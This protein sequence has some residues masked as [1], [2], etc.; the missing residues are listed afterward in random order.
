[1]TTTTLTNANPPDTIDDSAQLDALLSE[2]SEPAIETMRQLTGDVML[3]GV[4]GKM[5]PTLA[6]MVK[7][8]ADGA[9][10]S[11]RVIGVSR[12]SSSSGDLQQEL[13]QHSIETIKCD[14]LDESQLAKLPDCPN[15]IYMAGLKFG[16]SGNEALTWAM[17]THVPALVSQRFPQSRIAAFSTGNVYGLVPVQHG[18]SRE[19]DTPN[20][21][22]DY[23]ISCLGRERI[24]EHFSRTN[25]TPVSVIRLNYAT[26]LRYG[27]LVDIAQQ[28]H[29]G[30]PIDVT[31]PNMNV[32]WQ[33]DA[34]AY[35]IASLLHADS[36]PCWL[37]VAGP[38]LLSVRD[39]AQR[40]GELMGRDVTLTGSESPDALIN[41]GQKGHRLFGY[42]RIGVDRMLRW[43]AD[44]VQRGGETLGKP[45]HFE[46]RDGKF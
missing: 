27:V 24:F 35:T 40:F 4:G 3:L 28:V 32:I 2:P 43:I 20:P 21:D 11:R 39:V 31:M 10:T 44:W 23:A 38:E 19:A 14:L 22:G 37:N 12:F 42:P 17:N 5:G 7:R 15:I 46:V 26:E 45:T 16:S 13:E 41:N 1:M 6:R 34:N 18:G 9:G 25:G 29:A 30:Q 33:A 36:P 8:A